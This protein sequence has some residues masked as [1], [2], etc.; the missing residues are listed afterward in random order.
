MNAIADLATDRDLL[1][2]RQAQRV[3]RAVVGE[4]GVDREP[5]PGDGARREIAPGVPQEARIR[6]EAPV[7]H[8]LQ[9][10]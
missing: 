8:S 4:A 9:C 2:R 1:E 3:A 10:D 5:Q 6:F 7:G